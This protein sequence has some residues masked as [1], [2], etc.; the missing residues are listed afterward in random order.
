MLFIM[1]IA[2]TLPNTV[3]L[4]YPVPDYP[5]LEITHPAVS[6]RIA[7]HGAHLL[8]WTPTGQ[9][10]VLYL[11]P[12]S[13]FHAGNP[14]RG[15]VPICWPWFGPH[16]SN[17]ALPSHGFARNRFWELDS[18]SENTPGVSLKFTLTDDAETRSIWPHAFRLTLECNIGATLSLSLTMKNTGE[19]DFTITDA[20]HTYFTVGDI[21]RISIGGLDGAEYLDTRWQRQSHLQSGNILF[22]GEVDSIYRS[23]SAVTLHDDSWQ[24]IITVKSGGSHSTVVWNPWKEK[25]AKLNDLPDED[26]HRFVCV[27]TANAWQDRITLSPGS[28]H[29]LV[30]TISCDAVKT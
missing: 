21:S 11:S 6:A 19:T 27:E 20:L 24:R 2:M 15:G 4:S 5:V 8:E 23:S 26:Y 1:V 12:Q 13:V 18:A 14:V 16:D 3:Q 7:L 29:R 17:A 25:A 10:P 22:T 9:K 28:A 30:T